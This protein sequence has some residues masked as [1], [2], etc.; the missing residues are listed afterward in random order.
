MLKRQA[1]GQT[2]KAPISPA[3]RMYLPYSVLRAIE[4]TKD[5]Q[6]S[7]GDFLELCDLEIYFLR[8]RPITALT[9]LAT[10]EGL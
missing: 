9:N 3:E 5:D 7:Y 2:V 4:R 10:R 8:I 1:S 6:T